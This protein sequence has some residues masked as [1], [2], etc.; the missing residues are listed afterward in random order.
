M[1]WEYLKEMV[2]KKFYADA[3]V[4]KTE[5]KFLNLRAGKM[6][7]REY[8]TEFNRM[9]RL[10]PNMVNT[11]AKRIKCYLRGLPQ[12]VSTLVRASK[13]TTFDSVIK[14]VEM[15]YDDLAVDDVG[16]MEE[17]K[18]KKW[19]AHANRPGTQLWN[20][21]E[22][23]PKVWE[24]K[25]CKTCGK[26]YGGECKWGIGMNTCYKCGKTGHYSRDCSS[27]PVCYKCGKT[28]HMARECTG[29]EAGGRSKK[30]ADQNRPKTRA[31]M[32]TQEQAKK[33][34]DIMTGTFLVNGIS[35][36]VLFYAG[37][38]MSFVATSFCKTAKMVCFHVPE[39]FMVETAS[40]T[41][42]KIMRMV[43]SCKIEWEGHEF[44]DT[45]CVLTLGG[46]D[47]VLGM[48]WLFEFEAQ[49]V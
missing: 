46:S 34:P 49:I 47:V 2:M 39:T 30:G 27:E 10:V 31:Y 5:I 22:K 11:E 4:E 26:M 41:L 12:N 1:N 21:K 14:L 7:H 3:E 33:I 19:V 42:V 8:T 40:E 16:V 45:L 35:A 18:E 15:V 9:S 13:P 23:K 36:S 25:S 37:A 32:L 44:P 48:D 28:G 29:N 24:K 43:K 20:S 38:T 17:K 6:T